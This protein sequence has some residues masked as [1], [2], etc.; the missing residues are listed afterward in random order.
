MMTTIKDHVMAGAAALEAEEG[1]NID[2][3]KYLNASTATSCIRRQWYERNRPPVEQ[4]WGYARRGKQ[5]ELYVVDCL[6]AAGVELSYAGE[7]QLSI[8]HGNVSGTPDGYIVDDAG[9]TIGIEIKS[10]D[11]RTNR[12]NLPKPE[13]VAQLQICMELARHQ[14]QYPQPVAGRLVYIDASNFNDVIEYEIPRDPLVRET[15]EPRAVKMLR[16]K[17][18]TRLD[19]EGKRSGEC[20][21]YSGCPFAAECGVQI[22]GEATVSRGNAGSGLHDAVSQYVTASAGI[23][24]LKQ[25]VDDAKESIKQGLKARNARQLTVGQHVVTLTTTAG[26]VSVDWRSAE[27][28][29]LNLEPYKKTGAAYETLTVK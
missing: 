23:A 28:A 18:P 20:K 25:Q 21:K 11:P 27:K 14:T 4:D 22:E 2:R 8:T 29:G 10:I 13:H 1:F 26:R 6:R 3:A 16:S 24:A 17:V 7:D 15:M 19:R 12:S 5:A 9:D